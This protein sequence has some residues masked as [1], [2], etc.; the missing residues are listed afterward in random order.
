MSG[1]NEIIHQSV[2]LK[3]MGALNAQPGHDMLDFKQLKAISGATDG[4]LG[5]HLTTLETAGYI[6]I[7]KDFVGKRP[8]TRAR[9]TGEGRRA[10]AEHVAFLRSILDGA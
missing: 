7:Q 3:I 4:N 9:L 6:A 10:F 5:A 1:A 2:R 8:R